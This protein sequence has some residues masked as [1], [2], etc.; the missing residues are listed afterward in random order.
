MIT[1]LACQSIINNDTMTKSKKKFAQGNAS[2]LDLKKELT[3]KGGSPK[4]IQKKND[5][6]DEGPLFKFGDVSV[7]KEIKV[8]EEQ[9]IDTVLTKHGFIRYVI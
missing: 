8:D 5:G 2:K 1:E 3:G 4:N 6:K 7:E 9:V